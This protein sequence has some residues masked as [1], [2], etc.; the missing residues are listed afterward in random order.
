MLTDADK[1]LMAYHGK[2]AALASELACEELALG[3]MA[4]AL[5]AIENPTRDNVGVLAILDQMRADRRAK[6]A[7]AIGEMART[8][9]NIAQLGQVPEIGS[10]PWGLC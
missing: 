8:E 5:E 2:C 10:D 7:T 3:R 1:R 9:R 4:R 6:V